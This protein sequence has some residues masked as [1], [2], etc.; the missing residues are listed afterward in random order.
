MGTMAVAGKTMTYTASRTQAAMATAAIMAVGF[1]SCDL[2]AVEGPSC[3][4][5]TLITWGAS[6]VQTCFLCFVLFICG[7]LDSAEQKAKVREVA[8]LIL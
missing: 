3:K 8:R 1:E 4:G 6:D 5:S 2:S 7:L